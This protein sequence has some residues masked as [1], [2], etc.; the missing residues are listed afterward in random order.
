MT[1]VNH[2]DV[3][4]LGQCR[5]CGRALCSLC[6]YFR[7]GQVYC[8]DHVGAAGAEVAGAPV[9]PADAAPATVGGDSPLLPGEPPTAHGAPST[10]H[11]PQ[12]TAYTPTW[13]ADPR[14]EP[15]P[16]S[17]RPGWTD[18]PLQAR[19]STVAETLGIVGLVLSLISLPFNLCCGLGSVVAGPLA[20]IAG[21]CAIAALVLAAKAPNPSQARWTGGLGLAL[22][23]LSLAVVA[24]YLV[25]TASL[26]GGA[27]LG[28]LPTPYIYWTP[29]P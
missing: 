2:P 6:V 28:G 21:G 16:M 22:A 7:A 19:P 3:P 9:V 27:F 4:A 29:T 10:A 18:E 24:C 13:A 1:C 20:L 5:V 14:L 17:M 26:M 12:P 8:V 23:L 11:G 25:F 15:L